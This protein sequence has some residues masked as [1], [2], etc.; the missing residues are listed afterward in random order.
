MGSLNRITTLTALRYRNY[1]NYWVGLLVAVMGWQILYF[2]QLWL[3]YELTH[4]TLYLGVTGGA[5]G[6]AHICFSVFGG[7]FADRMDKRRLIIFTQSTMVILSFI[8]ATLIITGLVNVWHIIILA[9]LTGVTSA[10]DNP[11]R[12]ALIPYLI[13]DSKDLTNAVALASSVWSAAR[14]VG[15]ALAGVIIVLA[16]PAICFYITSVSCGIMVLS[17][18]RLSVGRFVVSQTRSGLL[19]EFIE[20]WRLVLSNRVFFNLITITFLNSVFGMSFVY[21]LPVFATDILAAGPSG[22]GFLMTSFGVGSILG[23]LTVA[24]L[25]EHW[26]RGRVLLIGNILFCALLIVFSLSRSYVFSI[27]LIALTGFFNSIYMTNVLTLLQAL[28][29]DELRGRIMGIYSLTWSLMPLG[30]MQAGA[31]AN[32]VGVSSVVSIGGLISLSFAMFVAISNS[33]IRNLS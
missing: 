1:R 17:L 18:T 31:L 28:V 14:V 21:L 9:A 13:D 29:P 16:G 23:V 2:T 19:S 10:F 26:Y 15:P 25:A 6:V 7:V 3:V 5:T 8:L 20:G 22:F 30:G 11:A 4:S 27:S 24:S 33:R 12:Q 32:F